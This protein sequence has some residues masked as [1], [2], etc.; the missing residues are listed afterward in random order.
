MEGDDWGFVPANNG[1]SITVNGVVFTFSTAAAAAAT[2]NSATSVTVNIGGAATATTTATAYAAAFT[3]AT[4]A[5]PAAAL[6]GLSIIDLGSGMTDTH[7]TKKGTLATTGTTYSKSGVSSQFSVISGVDMTGGTNTVT[8]GGTINLSSS[9]TFTLGGAGSGLTYGGMSALSPALTKLSTVAV[10]TVAHSNAA[11]TILDAAL[12]QV[13][14]QRASLGAVQNRFS[15]TISNLNGVSENLTGARS[16]ITD[17]DFA[18]ETANLTRGQI[19][20]QAGTA[21][22]AQANSLPNG[23]LALLRG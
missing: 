15:A 16:R 9:N 11:I 8:T 23:V 4:S 22:L 7:D 14:S 10:D 2:I 20:Q 13:S 5:A 17:A 6:A 19:L 21:M 18:Q 3:A 12:A 1:D